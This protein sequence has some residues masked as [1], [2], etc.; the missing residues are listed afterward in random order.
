MVRKFQEATGTIFD[1]YPTFKSF[2]QDASITEDHLIDLINSMSRDNGYLSGTARHVSRHINCTEKVFKA[3]QNND[4]WYIRAVGLFCFRRGED[5]V[6]KSAIDVLLNEN[7]D[8]RVV[9]K[10]AEALVHWHENTYYNFEM[11]V[12]NRWL[13][14]FESI[15]N[16]HESIKE[17]SHGA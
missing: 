14:V 16:R 10:A 12:N 9:R 13:F 7:E 6:T 17:I 8:V 3:M 4:L 2:T 5:K 11:H 1:N 15:T